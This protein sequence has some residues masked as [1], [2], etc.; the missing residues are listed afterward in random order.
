MRNEFRPHLLFV[1]RR[2]EVNRVKRSKGFD[3]SASGVSTAIWR[4]V[5]VAEVLRDWGFTGIPAG[6]RWFVGGGF[7]GRLLH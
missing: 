4:G 5:P 2:G 6:E 1:D 3:W 7:S